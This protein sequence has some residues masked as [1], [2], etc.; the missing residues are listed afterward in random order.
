MPIL[1]RSAPGR[2]LSPIPLPFVC[3]SCQRS[4][5]RFSVTSGRASA[6]TTV[7]ATAPPPSPSPSGYAL[8]TSRR[9]ISLAGPDAPKFLHGL[10]T[11]SVVDEPGGGNGR[12]RHNTPV[13]SHTSL[14][15][16]APGFYSGFLNATGRVLHDV[17]VYRDTLGIN[18]GAADGETF[19]VEVDAA[20][21]DTLARHIKRYKLRSKLTF[22]VLDEGE[23]AAWQVW[24]GSSISSSEN[25][26][27]SH[28]KDSIIL[29]DTRAPGMGYRVLRRGGANG[30]DVDLAQSDDNM[31]RVRRYLLGV[32]EGQAEIP[33][34]QALPL[35][36]NM[37][38]MGGIDFRKGCYVGQ[39]L[40]IRTRHR[41]IVRKRILPCLL[42]PPNPSPPSPPKALEY[43]PYISDEGTH[44]EGS[45]KEL[46]AEDIP[47]NLSIGR[48]GTKGRSA[49]TWLRG[50]GNIGLALCRLQIMTDVELP[51]ETAVGAP[52]DP[53]RDEFVVKWGADEEGSGGQSVK[54]KA[55]V[56]DWMRERLQEGT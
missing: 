16:G 54:I 20:Q 7:T 42:Y 6:T 4:L 38:L 48:D 27:L 44:G 40:T 25:S 5:R 49:G 39:E 46:S 52:F 9:L 2:G 10:I 3:Q 18:A 14:A 23:I 34:E 35:E 41:G 47:S 51:G 15:A 21:V 8:L 12:H 1:P 24:D 32:A 22:R 43:K 26:P 53:T 36:A 45:N 37:D 19:V 28:L 30:L 17:F 50:V 29:P 13:S 33:R 56:P 55:F 31:Y 11:Q